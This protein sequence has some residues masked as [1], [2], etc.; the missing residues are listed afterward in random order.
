[1][2]LN[3]VCC[4]TMQI[5]KWVDVPPE[6]LCIPLLESHWF[7]NTSQF[8]TLCKGVLLTALKVSSRVPSSSGS[9]SGN[10]QLTQKAA[11]TLQRAVMNTH[12]FSQS[13]TAYWPSAGLMNHAVICYET[14]GRPSV[15]LSKRRDSDGKGWNTFAYVNTMI[16][17]WPQ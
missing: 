10:Q 7:T 8:S 14:P 9:D 16:S 11:R 17:L 15:R 2:L 12:V 3:V 5:S 1:M 13:I 4:T 6:D